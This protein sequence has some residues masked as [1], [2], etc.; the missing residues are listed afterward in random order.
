MK[1]ILF[2]MPSL[3]I[4]GAERSLL[5]L[6]SMIDYDNYDVSLFLYRHEGEF[7]NYISSDVNLI[8]AIEEY[9][10]FD[11]PIKTLLLSKKWKYGIARLCSK[12]SMK[13]HC[14]LSHERPGVWMSMQYISK[15]LLPLLP[16]I[17]GDYD[18]AISYLGIPDVLLEKT[19]A[20]KKI[21]WNHTDYSVLNPNKK[22]DIEIYSKLDYVVSVSKPCTEQFL[23][24]YPEFF[25]KA[26]TIENSLSIELLKK[27]AD[28]P[29]FD[30]NK[31]GYDY[32]LLSIGRYSDAKNFDNIPSIC[33]KIR[34]MGKNVIW[35]IIGY[36]SEEMTIR[37]RIKENNMESYVV[38]LGKKSNPYPYIR[39]CDV[40]IQP[41]RYE[42]KAV[43]V[44]EAQAL[45][46]PVVITNFATSGSQLIN[47]Y[48]GIIVPL[49]NEG[50][51]KG[52]VDLL[53]DENKIK[54]IIKNT[55]KIDYSNKN[56]LKKI[57][58]IIG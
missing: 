30:M 44:R 16:P 39:K 11:V 51:A 57:Y 46:K 34:Q 48:D 17:P 27:E 13:I 25:N 21:C 9:S 28:K 41:S 42:G 56:E 8:P 55:Y 36:G 53:N 24:I 58:D 52:I 4:G 20:N 5:S 43:T 15:S 45:H 26:I 3:F 31:N 50:C 2:I 22:R 12:V 19:K 23:K 6:L 18:M 37:Q 14:F 33:Q 38:L 54:Y 1:K 10:T 35:Y 7:L 32:V 49:D 29:I 40:Y 47:G